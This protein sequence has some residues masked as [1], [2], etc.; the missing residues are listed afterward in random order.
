MA[1]LSMTRGDTPTF[2]LTITDAAGDAV[3]LTDATIA[4]TAKRSIADSATVFQKTVGSGV[5]VTNAAGGLAS[6]LLAAG[7]TTALPD[8]TIALHYDVEVVESDGT[9]T[10]VAS[11]LLTVSP[12]VNS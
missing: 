4:F 12:D 1:D 9:K 11:G 5:T 10:T 6:V 3:D 7:D 2:D 8:R